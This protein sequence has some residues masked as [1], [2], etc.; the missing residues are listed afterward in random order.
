MSPKMPGSGTVIRMDA[1]FGFDG[2]RST[3]RFHLGQLRWMLIYPEL[4]LHYRNLMETEPSQ[5]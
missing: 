2:N 3:L 5:T 1:I 4:D